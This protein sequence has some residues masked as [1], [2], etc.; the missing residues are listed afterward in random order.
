MLPSLL[1]LLA[2][3]APIDTV[4]FAFTITSRQE[5][6]ASA[7]GQGTDRT[8]IAATG[9]LRAVTRDSAGVQLVEVTIDTVAFRSGNARVSL[10]TL[11]PAAGTRF[12]LR[13]EDGE[14]VAPI[15]LHPRSVGATQLLGAVGLL[16]PTR[17]LGRLDGVPWTDSSVTATGGERARTSTTWRIA[18]REGAT[19]ALTG[20]V[21]GTSTAPLA[22][23]TLHATTQGTQRVVTTLTGPALAA[24]LQ[25]ETTQEVRGPEGVRM[26]GT[27]RRAIEVTRLP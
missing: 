12:T 21:V 24:Q 11:A 20:Q 26:R 27:G 18:S 16:Y 23:A 19:I 3:Q 2:L 4:R 8:D 15:G 1:A 5:V 25:E 9:R 6:D 14:L 10:A 22:G 17:V 7:I 13:V